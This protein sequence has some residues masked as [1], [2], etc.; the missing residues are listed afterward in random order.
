[1]AVGRF[2]HVPC[3][4][5]KL[6]TLQ[7]M[8]RMLCAVFILIIRSFEVER[9]RGKRETGSASVCGNEEI[10]TFFMQFIKFWLLSCKITK[11]TN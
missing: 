9:L 7:Y 3:S 2:F 6:K 10:I 5:P 4:I 1:M 11:L 8:K